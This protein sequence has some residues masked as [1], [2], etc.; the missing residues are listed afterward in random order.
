MK[1]R[2]EVM[3]LLYSSSKSM[4]A[5]VISAIKTADSIS[6]KNT[7]ADDTKAAADA[8]TNAAKTAA[9]S[10]SCFLISEISDEDLI[11]ESNDDS[12]LNMDFSF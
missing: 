7:A 6:L 1:I 2:K 8:L 10:E 11:T 12:F 9:I 3:K 4:F 5:A